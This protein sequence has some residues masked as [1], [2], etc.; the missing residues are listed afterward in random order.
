[1]PSRTKKNKIP[2]KI[3]WWEPKI[4]KREY[5]YIHRVLK[6]N[7]PNEGPLTIEFEKKLSKLLKVKYVVL[8]PNCTCAMFLSLKALGVGSGDEVIVPDVTFI[9]TA[10]AVEM[11][12]AKPILV[13]I[14]P[15]RLTLDPTSF[16][17]SI[18][19]K[20]KAVIP[21]HVSGRAVNMT[22]ILE[23]AKDSNISVVEDAAEAFMSMY[24]GKYLGTIGKAGCF[25]LSPAKT[26]TT[27]QGGFI[28]TNNYNMY[29][30]LIE[31]KDQGRPTRGT[32]G[33][34]IHYTI[35]YNF[36]FTDL[37]AAV[38]LGQLKYLNSRVKRLRR[39]Y[40]LYRKYLDNVKGIKILDFD[41][42]NG[43][44]PQWTDAI[45][46]D[47][48]NLEKYL[49]KQ[50][51]DCR[52]LWFPI[53]QQKPYKLPDAIFPNSTKIAKRAL[54]LPSAY[55]FTDKDIKYVCSHIKKFFKYS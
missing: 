41:I 13:D 52:N 28:A 5:A 30:S 2:R 54:W 22:K 43:E 34:D 29:T 46:T 23:I 49:R 10:N 51:I 42:D 19:K 47:R 6:N 27:G 8:V 50:F 4:G 25:S 21:V 38:G 3:P 20:T 35:G 11:T 32:G 37:Q 16:K 1:M 31:L 17:K 53:H 33:D 55:T 18:T 44:L 9:A 48:D 45:I 39:N 36:K 26:I 40:I 7:Y 12:G 15:Q 14:D 24:K